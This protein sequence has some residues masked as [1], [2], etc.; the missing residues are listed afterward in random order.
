MKTRRDFLKKA[1]L[2]GAS[3]FTAPSLLGQER[4]EACF[5]SPESLMIFLIRIG[6]KENGIGISG[7]CGILGLIRLL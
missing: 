3:A 6:E 7:I 1:A 4:E 5:F 2:F